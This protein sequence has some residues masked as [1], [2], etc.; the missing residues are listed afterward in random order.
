MCWVLPFA[1]CHIFDNPVLKTQ[2]FAEP[3]AAMFIS[4]VTKTEWSM[5]AKGIPCFWVTHEDDIARHALRVV[6]LRTGLSKVTSRKRQNTHPQPAQ[7]R[8]RSVH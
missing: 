4:M 6:R 8:L 5:H 1:A 2:H 3:W 7:N